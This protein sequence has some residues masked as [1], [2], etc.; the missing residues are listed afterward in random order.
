MLQGGSHPLIFLLL[1]KGT[2]GELMNIENICVPHKS[3]TVDLTIN[4][5]TYEDISY[6]QWEEILENVTDD[7]DISYAVWDGT[8]VL[9]VE[10]YYKNGKV[11][12][13][14]EEIIL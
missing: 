3:E 11:V 14:R 12:N 1:Y 13:Y 5:K 2:K 7:S 9:G 8:D 10:F 6:Y 4:D